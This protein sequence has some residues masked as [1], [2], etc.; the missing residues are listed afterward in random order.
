[1]KLTSVE[2]KEIVESY[3]GKTL[4]DKWINHSLCVGDTAGKIAK[5]SKPSVI[6][7]A[8]AEPVIT[9]TGNGIKKMPK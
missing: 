8:L 2:A 5:A 9:K 1:M 4:N 3:R 6:F 7:T